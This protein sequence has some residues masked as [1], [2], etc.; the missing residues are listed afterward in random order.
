MER[1]RRRRQQIP[2]FG[3]WNQQ[4]CEELP[5][6]QYFESAMQA[7]LVVRAGRCCYH[8][9]GTEAAA[10]SSRSPSG[11]PPPHK[12]AKKARSAMESHQQQQVVHAV[13]RRRQQGAP[14]VADGGPRAPRRPRVVRSVDEDLY[15]VH[16]DL[17]PKK[18][19]PR[20]NVRS[21]WM[22]CVGLNCVA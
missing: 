12:P 3:E 16:P 21:L 6:T 10:L 1:G 4:Q 13:S 9:G 5:M 17:L 19:K 22:G 11:S 20:K 8:H 15:K 2:V 7:G 14:L 18:G